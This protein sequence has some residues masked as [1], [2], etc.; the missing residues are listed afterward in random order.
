MT[1]TSRSDPNLAAEGAALL[2][3]CV[4]IE[5]ALSLFPSLTDGAIK[6]AALYGQVR[7]PRRGSYFRA[8]LETLARSAT[9]RPG[10]ERNAP[11]RDD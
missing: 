8:D 3:L 10:R 1:R 11:I 4:T 6:R 9:C 7:C 2:K 5:E